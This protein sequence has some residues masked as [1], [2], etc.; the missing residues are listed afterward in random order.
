[1]TWVSFSFTDSRL[2]EARLGDIFLDFRLEYF[3]LGDMGY[4]DARLGDA[5]LVD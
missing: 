1:M 2:G 3:R 4:L 5:R